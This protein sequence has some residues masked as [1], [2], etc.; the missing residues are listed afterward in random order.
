[1]DTGD[2]QVHQETVAVQSTA[3]AADGSIVVSVVRINAT[4]GAMVNEIALEEET[5]PRGSQCEVQETPYFSEV[6]GSVT[7]NDQ[8]A[9]PGTVVQAVNPRGD[10]VGCFTVGSAGLYGFM[11][12]YGED[13]SAN[14]PIPGMRDGELVAFRV[15]GAPAVATPLFYWQDDHATHRVDLAAGGIE[16]Q[17]VLFNP[18]WNLTSFRVAPP[19]PSVPQ[20]LSSIDGRYDRVLGET[21]IYA[22]SLPDVFNTLQELRA[23]RGYYLRL[24]GS[25]STNAL[26]EGMSVPVTTSIPLHPGWNWIGYLPESTLPITVALQSIEGHYQ[27]VLSLDK[28]YDPALPEFSTLKQMGPGQGYLIHATSAVTFT[29]PAGSS[30]MALSRVEDAATA[31]DQ[32]SPTPYLTLVYGQ[33]EING[34]PAPVGT[35]VDVVTPH[36]DMAGC[37]VVERAGQFG[38]MHVYGEDDTA[39]PVIAGFRAGEP[40]TFRVNDL[41]VDIS[42]ATIWQD[43]SAPHFITL[44]AGIYS[45]Y[46]PL[47]ERGW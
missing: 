7:V 23:A 37:F 16:G 26:V 24:T 22:P 27:R 38:L 31:C 15:N 43:D 8:P 3:Y 10:T 5:L 12:I 34:E 18:G 9:P 14:P 11:R 44:S 33:V 17:S 21:G 42:T 6:Y 29:Y 13:A 2:Y 25:T 30:A 40:L 35:R 19:V 4:S 47:V 39:N 46:L 28:T 20:V 36:G 41:P 1:V 45:L 32:V